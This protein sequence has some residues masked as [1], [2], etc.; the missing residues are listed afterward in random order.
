MKN[1]IAACTIISRNYAAY[2]K[3]LEESLRH[4]NPEIDFHVL[5]VDVRDEDFARR[6]NFTNLVWVEDLNIPNFRAMAFQ[7]D[8]LELNTDV[9]PFMLQR[10]ATE[11]EYFYYLD[12][13]IHVYGSL[14]GLTRRLDGNTAIITPHITS[15][16]DDDKK[17]AEVDFLK[18]GMYNLGFFGARACE[19]SQ[20]LLRWWGQRCSTLGF[21]DPRQ[22]LF[23]DQRLIDF[24]PALFGGV[25][26]ERSPVY[27]A[28]YWN[29][30][31]RRL[32]GGSSSPLVNGI[33]LVFFHFSG[34]SVDP[35]SEPRL[36]ISKY[37]NRFD[38]ASRP[39]VAP[40][41]EHYRAKLIEH[42]HRTIRDIPYG[43]GHFS[44][45]ERINAVSRRLFSLAYGATGA[46][47]PSDPFDVTGP[48]YAMLNTKHALG[49]QAERV[50]STF[51]IDPNSRPLRIMQSLLRAAFRL[52]GPE[53]YS[54]LMVYFGYISSVRNQREIFF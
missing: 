54:R 37:Q 34:L 35:P 12:P 17:P 31:E 24:A 23:V 47:T 10:L 30:H 20:R 52:L 50:P 48:V 46:A 28:A 44:N 45:G 29:L 16:I 41:F 21:N 49:G 9:K 5:V 43:F 14:A 22:G 7:F 25:V 15:P 38:F 11:Y 33:P 8:I 26:I 19:E 27:N 18:A 1:R 36:E 2:A 39:D 13:D 32:S 42:G 40:L 3:T 51:S 53:R 4:T 6:L